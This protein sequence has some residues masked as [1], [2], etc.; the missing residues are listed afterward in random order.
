MHGIRAFGIFRTKQMNTMFCYT[1]RLKHRPVLHPVTGS[2]EPPQALI[3]TSVLDEIP[4]KKCQVMNTL[5]FCVMDYGRARFIW[6]TQRRIER[7]IRKR[8]SLV[9]Y[10]RE[11]EH[12]DISSIQPNQVVQSSKKLIKSFINSITHSKCFSPKFSSPL[13]ASGNSN[14]KIPHWTA[15]QLTCS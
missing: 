6:G 13:L 1:M 7:Q 5:N 4:K 15:F 14:P 9:L 12:D 8:F 3:Q 11:P 10:K 2:A